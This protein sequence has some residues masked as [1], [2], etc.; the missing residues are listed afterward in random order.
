MGVRGQTLMYDNPAVLLPWKAEQNKSAEGKLQWGLMVV[1]S[2]S[3]QCSR[4]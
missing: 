3:T 2:S 1:F 4:S